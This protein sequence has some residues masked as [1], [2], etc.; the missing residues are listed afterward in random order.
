MLNAVKVAS[1]SS[2]DGVPVSPRRARNAAQLDGRV[3][4]ARRLKAVLAELS[5]QYGDVERPLLQR[6]AELQL[7]SE[8]ARARLVRGEPGTT[9]DEIVKLENLSARALR[10][11]RART[12][13][14]PES[15]S[16]GELLRQDRADQLAAAAGADD[17]GA[18]K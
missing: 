1:R 2:V 15:G 18:A 5:A 12:K 13:R 17:D 16:L 9:I 3:R 10:D 14:G 7:L 8:R 4:M 6:C 11:L